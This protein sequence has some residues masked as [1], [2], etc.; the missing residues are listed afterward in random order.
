MR[1]PYMIPRLVAPVGDGSL[2]PP[3]L[4]PEL[5][6]PFDSWKK[7]TFAFTCYENDSLVSSGENSPCYDVVNTRTDVVDVVNTRTDV[8]TSLNETLERIDSILVNMLKRAERRCSLDAPQYTRRGV[9]RRGGGGNKIVQ[10]LDTT[11]MFKSTTAPTNETIRQM[12]CRLDQDYYAQGLSSPAVHGRAGRRI[13]DA[14]RPN[15]DIP[16]ED[17]MSI[18]RRYPRFVRA[19]APA[20][21]VVLAK[22]KINVELEGPIEGLDDLLSLLDKYPLR[23]DAVYDIDLAAVHNVRP[24]LQSLQSMIGLHALKKNIV[25]QVMYFTQGFHLVGKDGADFMHTVIHGPPGTGKTDVARIMGK[26][27]SKL[28]ILKKGTFRK[29][30]RSDLVAGYLGQT[31]IKTSDVIKSALGGVLFID[32]AY[33]LGNAE[34][35]DSFAKECIDTLCEA[36]S[37]HKGELMVIV[38]GYE[39]ELKNC[40]F[41][42]NQGLESRFV[43]RF[44]TDD[45][46]GEELKEIFCKKV[47]DAGWSMDDGSKAGVINTPWF[48]DKM[49]YFKFFGRDMETLLSKVKIAHSRRVFGKKL[50]LKTK[51]TSDDME[52]GLQLYLENDEVKKRGSTDVMNRDVLYSMYS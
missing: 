8:E 35:K 7:E 39:E 12:L 52:R 30:T 13:A 51:I 20:R 46:S 44:K 47:R 19:P 50:E 28:G 5:R 38:A 2:H 11:G 3:R 33:A 17:D 14:F 40:F 9:E 1:P 37:D 22:E 25:D 43:W 27:F 36:L 16:G 4:P 32:E 26:V 10:S 29:V 21:G 48:A 42:Y 41:S 31:A 15:P 6:Q 23:E 24:E 18:T 34:K 45:Y 49:N